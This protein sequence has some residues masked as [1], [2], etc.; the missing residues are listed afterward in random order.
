LS[1]TSFSHYP[2]FHLL[3]L[4]SHSP[5]AIPWFVSD[6]IPSDVNALLDALASP[7][8]LNFTPQPEPEA[9]PTT[10]DAAPPPEK[11][12]EVENEEDKDIHESG[13]ED[14][15]KNEREEDG[16]GDDGEEEGKTPVEETDQA[17][18][19]EEEGKA[20]AVEEDEEG[21]VRASSPA[22]PAESEEDRR[23]RILSTLASKWRKLF[24][25]GAFVLSIDR[26]YTLGASSS[27]PSESGANAG[28]EKA[29]YWSTPY[30][31]WNM[32]LDAPQ[33][34]DELRGSS[35][36]VFKGDLK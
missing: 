3:T 11:V 30:P 18:G 21:K 35:L 31:Y 29:S 2:I 17:G 16:A 26:T 20:E 14:E 15:V 10:T 4:T 8:F 22:P 34:L 32:H 28:S 9:E 1:H 27:T 7:S 25:E 36:V 12:E 13:K 19:I 6:V 24:D 23:H 33:L 5:K